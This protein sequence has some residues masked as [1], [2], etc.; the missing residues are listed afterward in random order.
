MKNT[1]TK[2][3]KRLSNL[4]PETFCSVYIDASIYHNGKQAIDCRLYVLDT[5]HEKF[6]ATTEAAALEQASAYVG[7]LVGTCE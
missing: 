5:I 7:N 4:F 1:V 3:T 2:L 6:T